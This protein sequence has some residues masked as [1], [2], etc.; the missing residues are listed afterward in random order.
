MIKIYRAILICI[1]S[2][3][4]PVVQRVISLVILFCIQ[5]LVI[6][7][8]IQSRHNPVFQ[9][10]IPLVTSQQQQCNTNH[11]YAAYTQLHTVLELSRDRPRRSTAECE[12]ICKN[13]HFCLD[14]LL[15]LSRVK[16]TPNLNSCEGKKI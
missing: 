9:R 4:N 5:S 8:C 14:F 10:V 15:L 11:G 13:R 16:Q 12:L 1:Q 3:L 6:L 2:R 7:I